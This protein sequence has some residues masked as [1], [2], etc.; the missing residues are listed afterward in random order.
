[1][2]FF[3]ANMARADQF[4]TLRL[5]WQTQLVGTSPSGS[6]LTSRA[7]TASNYWVTLNTNSTRTYLWSDAP[8]GG[9]SAN[10]TTTFT[11]LEAMALAWATP[12][13]T[14]QGNASLAAAI[15][16]S[17]DWMCANCYS[18]T[19]TEYNNWWDW[20]IGSMEALDNVAVLAYPAL[21]GTQITNYSRSVDRFSPN[22]YG[23]RNGV[24]PTN[25]WMTGANLTDQC[26]GMV[27]R[28]ILGKSS[29]KMSYAQT[30]LGSVFLYVTNS[31]GFYRDGSF[32]QHGSIAYTGTYGVVLL[33][34]VA[35]LVN[36][37]NG[38]AWQITDPNLTNVYNWVVNSYQPLIYNGAMMDMVRGR[39]IS[40][41]AET[42]S[43]DGGGAISSINQVAQLAPT[44][45]AAA[46][47]NWTASP[48]LPPGQ[49][50]FAGMDRVVAWRANFCF[51]LSMSS[52]R[53]ANYESIN[54]ENLHG[55]FT[56]DGMT[57]LYLGNPDTQFTGDFWPTI[58][59]YHLPGTTVETNARANAGYEATTTG[60]SWVGGAQVANSYGAAGMSLAAVSTTLVA[61]KSWFMFDNEIV[62]LG[63]GIT[64]GGPAEIDTTVENRRLGI[65]P[66]A[67]FTANGTTFA[68]TMG[69]SSNLT[70]TT[71]CALDGVAGYYFPG[72]ATNLRAAFVANSGAWSNIN[73]GTYVATTTNLNTDDY[74]TLWFNHGVKPTNANYAYVI[75]PNVSAN[76]M[77]NYAASPDIVVLTNS[78][79]V[80][81]T[82]KPSLGIVA[83]NFWSDGTNSAGLISANK[84]SSVITLE[85][86]AGISVG[87]A[88]PTQTNSD[89]ITVILNRSA[90]ATVSADPGVT[91]LQLS[92]QIV[93]S[94]NVSGS[95][96]KTYQA[97]FVYPTP[98]LIWD[99]N[100]GNAG[101]Q[102][103]SGYW[104]Y[105]Y[106]WTVSGDISWN[107]SPAGV[108]VFGAGGTA[109]TVTLL[110]SHN[111][112]AMVFNP[113]ASGFYKLSGIGIITVTNGITVSNSAT[114]N[115]P[116]YLPANQTWL[117]GSNQTLTLNGAVSATPATIVNAN[118]GG[119]V[120]INS[121]LGITSLKVATNTILGGSGTINATTTLQNGSIIQAGN[122]TNAG[123]LACGTLNLGDG[124]AALT[125]SRFS[126]AAGGKITA[127]DLTVA[128][129][130]IIVLLDSNL[131]YGTNTL[132]NYSGTV[133]GTGLGGFKLGLLPALPTGAIAY[134]NNT[135]S[136]LQLIVSP[137]VA[138]AIVNPMYGAGGFSFS[139]G[140][141]SGQS[142]RVL[143]STNLSVPFTGWQVLTNGNFGNGWINFTDRAATNLQKFY[144][145]VSP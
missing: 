76:S 59:P 8:L 140:A 70:S 90:V 27:L 13:C 121:S 122:S 123:T 129:T 109:G 110:N 103:G 133:G 19:A 138:P 134:L 101:A 40:R 75:L 141:N 52:S 135:G 20:E 120:L 143:A 42:E 30:N 62:C 96:G 86:F 22:N 24:A 118:G 104:D 41:H 10:I 131:P 105:G 29:S 48:A 115:I 108:A 35:Q 7:T 58:D 53:I 69:W 60:Q 112:Y 130:N 77:P 43:S 9:A 28:A 4:D 73:N 92:P 113:V 39:A 102:D 137:P 89:S 46:F 12:G 64:C 98:S 47:T 81:A 36:L 38:S 99:A 5:Y 144:R 49:F 145:V 124:S 88:D 100:A 3:M 66:T 55:W 114:V 2:V 71:W 139:F 51:G 16:N 68:P 119:T 84:Q 17:L 54:G 34:D 6:T 18:T 117:L 80:Q 95:F 26:K 97:S 57:Y 56:G 116:L 78:P 74:L 82:S 45:T 61:K 31:D 107:D 125:Y 91:V 142:Y 21:T 14:L 72:G 132:L 126:I 67:N 136:A 44:A 79:I 87:V 111:A 94:V 15:T 127:T 33:G 11:R 93:L 63:A 65:A 25:G 106:W 32:V 128:G 1:M 85:N 50:Q 83:A 37:L 23:G